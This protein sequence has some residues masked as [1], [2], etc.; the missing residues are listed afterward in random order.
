VNSRTARAIQRNPVLKNKTKQTNKKVVKYSN[1][2][3]LSA[4]SFSI[5]IG[6]LDN[7]FVLHTT[8]AHMLPSS[9][10]YYSGSTVSGDNYRYSC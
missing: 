1:I 5:V 4:F 3:L 9:P 2:Q 8:Y 7:Y 10:I 6:V